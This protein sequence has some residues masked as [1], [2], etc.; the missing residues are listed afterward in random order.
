MVVDQNWRDG[1]KGE[2][3]VVTSLGVPKVK[4][5]LAGIDFYQAKTN[6][7]SNK[8][9]E[10]VYEV[11]AICFHFEGGS[12]IFWAFTWFLYSVLFFFLQNN[13]DS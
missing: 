10:I 11:K 9:V 6:E 3:A 7:K 13:D 5:M 4:P 12:C 1:D 8:S 2:G